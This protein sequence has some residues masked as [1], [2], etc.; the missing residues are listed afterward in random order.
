[1]PAQRTQG[2]VRANKSYAVFRLIFGL[3]I[4]GLGLNQFS[5]YP[6]GS[7]LPYFSLAVGVLFIVYGLMALFAGKA[8]GTTVDIQTEVPS[9]TER[10]AEITRLK[11]SGLISDQEF[12]AKRQ[13]IL[14]DL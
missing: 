9:A 8:V 5:R 7:M 11:Q 12:E 13:D 14:K 3:L 2:T 4:F 10:L 1:M 6:S